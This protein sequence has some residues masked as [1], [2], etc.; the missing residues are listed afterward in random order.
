[1]LEVNELYSSLIYAENNGLFMDLERIYLDMPDRECRDCELCCQNPPAASLLEYL[2]VYRYIR[3]ELPEKQEAIL[4]GAAEFFFLELADPEL[5]CPFRAAAGC[6]IAP[7]RPFGCRLFGLLSEEDY[8]KREQERVRH[9][10][11]LAD[12]LQA[13]YGIGLPEAVLQSRPYC[14][15]NRDG[16]R[17]ITAEELTDLEMRL[18]ALDTS[19]V[20]PERVFRGGTLVPLPVHLAMTV[21]NAGVRSK[22]LEVVRQFLSGSRELLEKYA[23]RAAGYRF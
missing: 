17:E 13:E 2:N 15:R 8:T 23:G 1:M 3:D 11:A 22:R 20:V 5:K 21:L 7:V 10:N 18:L 12:F 9:V 16:G 14:G 6:L 19:I 4:R